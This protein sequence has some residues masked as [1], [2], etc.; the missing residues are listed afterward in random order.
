MK[1]YWA[2]LVFKGPVHLKPDKTGKLTEPFSLNNLVFTTNTQE[3]LPD[4]V[5]T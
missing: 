2:K 5:K 1:E 3:A 4:G